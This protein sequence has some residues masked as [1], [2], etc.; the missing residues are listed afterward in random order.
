VY[1]GA[2]EGKPLQVPPG[3]DQPRPLRPVVIGV[4]EMRKPNLDELNPLPPRAAVTAGGGEANAYLA[5]SASGAYLAVKD[6]PRSVGRRLRYAIQRSGMNLQE[7]SDQGAHRFDY[8]H[9]REPRERGFF[10]KMMFWRE[11]LGPD[12]S[13]T[14][15]VRLQEDGKETRVYL[16]TPEGAPASTNAAEHILGIFM[17]RL[18]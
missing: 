11:S 2:E 15:V 4:E 1:L 14:Y 7:I 6:T 16:V 12:Y 10:E 17:E 9:V 5:W 8:Q 13:G 18:G 3:L